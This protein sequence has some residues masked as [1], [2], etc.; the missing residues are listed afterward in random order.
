VVKPGEKAAAST[1]IANMPQEQ[2]QALRF[3]VDAAKVAE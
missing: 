3:R 2:L 1:G